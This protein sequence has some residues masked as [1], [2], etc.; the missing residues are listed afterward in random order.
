MVKV[1]SPVLG[2]PLNGI[3]LT[4]SPW[5]VV[6]VLLDPHDCSVIK[7]TIRPK[8]RNNLIDFIF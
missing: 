2:T 8:R 6:V 4:Q 5:V 1:T 7:P 3:D